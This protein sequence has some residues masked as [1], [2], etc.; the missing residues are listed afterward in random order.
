[1]LPTS[2]DAAIP[3]MWGF[4]IFGGFVTWQPA[5]GNLTDGLDGLAIVP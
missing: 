1:M 4:F 2:K 5:I 3:L